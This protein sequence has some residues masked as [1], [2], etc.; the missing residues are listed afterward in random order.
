MLIGV[1]SAK[2]AHISGKVQAGSGPTGPVSASICNGSA[3]RSASRRVSQLYDEKLAPSGLRTT[4]YSVLNRIDRLGAASLNTL[5]ED[6]AM[7]R[8]TLGHNLRPLERDGLVL[9]GIDPEDRRTRTIS[10]SNAGK[11]KLAEARPLWAQAQAR[12][13]A[14]F[15]E[16]R[17]AMLRALLLEVASETFGEAFGA[18]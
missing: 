17:A 4:Q 13:E 2:A 1:D 14:T 6:L 12:F 8:S 9:L 16:E 3:L 11:K 5:A 10:L 7:D 15:G 18:T